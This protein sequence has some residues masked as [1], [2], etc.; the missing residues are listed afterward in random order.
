[1]TRT[2]RALAGLTAA[3]TLLAGCTVKKQEAPPLSGPS[4][5]ATSLQLT[6][7]PDTLRQDGASQS[8]IV[9]LA[10][11]STSQPVRNLPIRVE[12]A[13][14]GTIMDYGQVSAKNVVTGQDGR[15]ALVYTAPTAPADPVD[16]G[17]VVQILATPTGT[18]YANATTRTVNI[19]L[20]PPGIILPPNGTPVPAF[21]FS[22]TAPITQSDVTFD[23]SQSTD[24]DGVIVLYQLSF[25]DGS[26]GSGPIVRHQYV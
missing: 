6:A 23:A 8:Q 18:D 15:A 20:V 17:I 4:V 16:N 11:D 22:P 25:G 5:L 3:L 14:G 19:R 1:M 7:N 13:V 2:I 9:I 26:S 12:V 24:P 10:L 21:S